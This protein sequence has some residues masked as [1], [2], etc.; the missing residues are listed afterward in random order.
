MF[1]RRRQK[2]DTLDLSAIAEAVAKR[3]A[4]SADRAKLAENEYRK[5]LYL[6]MLRPSETLS[7]WPD[8]LDL[9][10]HEHILHTIKYAADCHSLFGR[11]INHDPS[12]SKKPTENVNAKVRTAL[13]YRYTFG[14]HAAEDGSSW[15]LPT[16]ASLA[17][18]DAMI[19]A[20]KPT[21][22]ICNSC[23]S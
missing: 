5:F 4:W 7:P 2:I 13:A 14:R 6:L 22:S 17:A 12:I 8:D 18:V 19:P 16:A 3:H 11:F 10:W 23:G 20:T 9:F 21:L 15:L 1:R